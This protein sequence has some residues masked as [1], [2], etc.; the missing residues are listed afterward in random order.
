[1]ARWSAFI[2][3]VTALGLLVGAAI[4]LRAALASAFS[5]GEIFGRSL[6]AAE[7]G[8]ALAEQNAAF[9]V[10]RQSAEREASALTVERERLREKLDDLEK[11]LGATAGGAV[12]GSGS[13]LDAGVV[14][15]LDS[16][17]RPG[18]APGA[19]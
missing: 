9:E 10:I 7:A 2:A 13:C 12:L 15:A 1:M 6:A 11:L 4:W 17:R 19:P 5:R 8:A 14:R 3:A 18:A 16:I